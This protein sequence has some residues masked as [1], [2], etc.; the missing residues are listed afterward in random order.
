[1]AATSLNDE[2]VIL[3]HGLGR[4]RRS[5]LVMEKK[6]RAQGYQVVNINYPSRHMPIDELAMVVIDQCL[7]ITHKLG[8]HRLDFVTHSMGGI[9]VRHY[10]RHQAIEQLHR[11]V[12]LGPPNQG[13][14][15]V[16]RLRHIPLFHWLHGP[17][18]S[19]LGTSGED[20]PQQLGAVDFELGII[21]GIRSINPLL[22]SLLP[23]QNDGKVSVE[24]TK[25]E[26]MQDFITIPSTHTFMMRNPRVID[27]VVHFLQFGRFDHTHPAH[28]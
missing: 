7:A 8:C 10:L 4:T 14:E 27:Q 24:N 12:M 5:M 19:Q 15:V 1:M 18:A 22:S 9:L 25:I 28:A 26:G 17:A 20:L 3:L 2:C 11:V 21:A 23:G 6:L 13:S 16:D